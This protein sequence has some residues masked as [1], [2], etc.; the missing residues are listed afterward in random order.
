MRQVA[1][2]ANKNTIGSIA[3][4]P[5]LTGLVVYPSWTNLLLV[6]VAMLVGEF[7]K[8]KPGIKRAFNVAQYSLSVGVA[9]F[10]YLW[11]GGKSIQVDETFLLIPHVHCVVVR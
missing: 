5:F 11:L 8:P 1:H 6:A 2:S 7:R 4:L 10:V 3:F 9:V